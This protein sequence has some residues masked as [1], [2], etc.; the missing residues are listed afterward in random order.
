M[1]ESLTLTTVRYSEGQELGDCVCSSL[2]CVYEEAVLRSGWVEPWCIRVLKELTIV[3]VLRLGEGGCNCRFAKA[4]TAI[5]TDW[6]EFTKD[7]FLN[8]KTLVTVLLLVDACIPPQQIDLDC[9]DWLGQNKVSWHLLL[10]Y[11]DSGSNSLLIIFPL[12]VHH[13]QRDINFHSSY[14]LINNIS[15]HSCK[16]LFVAHCRFQ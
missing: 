14:I 2:S 1:V 13:E 16:P 11:L 7:Y 5:R 3:K 10:L 15:L 9:M 4:P 6:N 8:R 12:L